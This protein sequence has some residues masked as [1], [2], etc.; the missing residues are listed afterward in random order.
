MSRFGAMEKFIVPGHIENAFRM[1]VQ[2]VY[3][4]TADGD[5]RRIVAGRSAQES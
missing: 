2:G 3:K 5:E 4:F 1:P